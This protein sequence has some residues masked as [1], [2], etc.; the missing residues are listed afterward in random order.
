MT[1]K[2]KQL[3][4]SKWMLLRCYYDM[5]GLYCIE[6]ES[7]DRFSAEYR[8]HPEDVSHLIGI[9]IY[10]KTDEGESRCGV[11]VILEGDKEIL[12][13]VLRLIKNNAKHKKVFRNRPKH[14]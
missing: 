9:P 12:E 11:R 8:E 4:I 6:F 1:S 14:K 13:T 5:M 10:C 2:P 3:E 7:P